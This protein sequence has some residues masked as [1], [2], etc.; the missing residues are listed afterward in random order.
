[1]LMKMCDR[2]SVQDALLILSCHE[3]ETPVIH[4]TIRIVNVK[5]IRLILATSLQSDQKRCVSALVPV[6]WDLIGNHFAPV[7][8]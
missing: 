1:M 4:K 7:I 3:A 2:R 8:K 6:A 5:I